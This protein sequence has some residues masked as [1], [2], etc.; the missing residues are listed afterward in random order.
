MG[1]FGISESAITETERSYYLLRRMHLN[2]SIR[3]WPAEMVAATILNLNS[4]P[5]Y[6]SEFENGNGERSANK[7]DESENR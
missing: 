7:R 3:V 5:N 2:S 4:A 6:L 1:D